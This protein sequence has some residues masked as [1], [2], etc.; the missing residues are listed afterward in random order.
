M[1]MPDAR[2]FA[3]YRGIAMANTELTSY[4]EQAVEAFDEDAS[5]PEYMAYGPRHRWR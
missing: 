5:V 3:L 1:L 4:D 2:W